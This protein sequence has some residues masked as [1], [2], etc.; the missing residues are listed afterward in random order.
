MRRLSTTERFLEDRTNRRYQQERYTT[1]W[2]T[3]VELS[4]QASAAGLLY[5]RIAAMARTDPK[6]EKLCDRA[7]F[8]AMRKMNIADEMYDRM[9]RY[10]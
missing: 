1:M 2:Y 8:R 4:K 9:Q 5:E 3:W 7:Y 6:A 10:A